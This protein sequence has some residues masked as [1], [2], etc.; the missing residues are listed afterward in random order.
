MALREEDDGWRRASY[1]PRNPMIDLRTAIAAARA[2]GDVSRD[3]MLFLDPL[4]A[5]CARNFTWSAIRAQGS[6]ELRRLRDR[7]HARS[8]GRHFLGISSF[9]TEAGFAAQFGGRPA[10]D[11]WLKGLPRFSTAIANPPRPPAQCSA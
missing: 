4:R 8:L 5:P 9:E 10:I 6:R 2:N 11:A 3:G 1:P 7:R